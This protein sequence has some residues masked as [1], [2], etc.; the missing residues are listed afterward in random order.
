MNSHARASLNA[1]KTNPTR[2]G[3][4]MIAVRLMGGLGNQLFQYAFGRQL[5]HRL[6]VPLHLDLRSYGEIVPGQ[7]LRSYELAVYPIRAEIA[8]PEQLPRLNRT[9]PGKLWNDVLS[10]LSLNMSIVEHLPPGYRND[11]PLKRNALYIGYW[12]SA[13]YFPKIVDELRKELTPLAEPNAA[14]AGYASKIAAGHAVSLH[15]RRG[16]YASVAHTNQTHGLAPLEY[17]CEA[18][19]VMRERIPSAVFFV[20]SDD[21][22][23]CRVNLPLGESAVFVEGNGGAMAYE[24][25]RLMSRCNHHIIANS[26]FSW[27]GAFLNPSTAKV[28]IAPARW[29]ADASLDTTGMVPPEWLR[30]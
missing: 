27:W 4:P 23:W 25:L 11:L 18:I 24:D 3:I 20:F 28:V 16:D 8:K 30:M 26:S 22:A 7:T 1:A 10:K 19:R 14:N 12:Q 2:E 9:R 15:V 29:F 13:N 6:G 5:S 21:L 17:Y